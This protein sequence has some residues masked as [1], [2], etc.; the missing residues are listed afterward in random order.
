MSL[1]ILEF[2]ILEASFMLKSCGVRRVGWWLIR[3]SNSQEFLWKTNI[4]KKKFSCFQ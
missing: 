4:D 1:L 3:F 2:L